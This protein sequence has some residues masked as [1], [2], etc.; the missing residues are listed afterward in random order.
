MKLEIEFT[1][2]SK[3][4]LR[5][6]AGPWLQHAVKD[7]VNTIGAQLSSELR[8]ASPRDTGRGAASI[9]P[10]TVSMR[11]V[12]ITMAGHLVELNNGVLP[13]TYS[14]DQVYFDL[15]GR[16]GGARGAQFFGGYSPA[17][18]SDKLNLGQGWVHRKLGLSGNT[19][20]VVAYRIAKKI[21]QRGITRHKGWIERV[22]SRA[23]H[24]SKM[25]AMI[26]QMF[27]SAWRRAR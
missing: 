27:V 4:T 17:D 1:A 3:A 24:A 19:A 10:Q 25:R 14:A 6:M 18:P 7:V 8:G 12:D 11:Q 26:G 9:T 20:R 15:L 22:S 2:E 23:V 21:E 13:G 5:K 16:E